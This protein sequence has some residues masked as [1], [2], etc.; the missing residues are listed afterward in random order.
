VA[1]GGTGLGVGLKY[2]RFNVGVAKTF[3][4]SSLD[5]EGEPVHISFGVRF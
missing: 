2:Q 5:P 1:S 3:T 4:A